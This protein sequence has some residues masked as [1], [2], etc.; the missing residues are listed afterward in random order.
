MMLEIERR[1]TPTASGAERLRARLRAAG[2]GAV[3]GSVPRAFYARD[4]RVVARELLGKILVARSRPELPWDAPDAG[5]T[6]G[7][8]VETEAYRGDDPA[9]HSA[10]GE[11][12]R[13]AIM[14]GEP[15]VAYVY[16]IYGMYEMLNFVTEAPGFP[17]AVL[18][19]ALEPVLGLELMR[20]RR[21]ARSD[22]ELARGPGKLCRALGIQL[23]HNGQSLRG[24]ALLLVDDGKPPGSISASP[25]VGISAGTESAWRYFITGHPCVSRAP[26]NRAARRVS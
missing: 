22:A 1:G 7:R 6:A 11:T 14:F 8:I 13:S 18:V 12:P 21:G 2:T 15:G 19:R 3:R 16:F 26:Q 4:T 10:R 20:R 23:S 17:G 24:P 9:S 25:R 5:V